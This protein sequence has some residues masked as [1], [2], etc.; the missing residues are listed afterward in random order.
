V[1][2]SVTSCYSEPGVGGGL[3]LVHN[4]F[5]LV[6]IYLCLAGSCQTRGGNQRDSARM[7][8]PKLDPDDMLRNP[9]AKRPQPN[10][11][12]C[13][14]GSGLGRKERTEGRVPREG[15]ILLMRGEIAESGRVGSFHGELYGQT[16]SFR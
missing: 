13:D 6:I 5:L 8:V 2:T 3:T 7:R 1:R 12:S 11:G 4:C 10:Q 9:V 15:L 16:S 14:E